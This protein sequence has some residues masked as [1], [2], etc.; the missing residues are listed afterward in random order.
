[1]TLVLTEAEIDGLLK[2][3]NVRLKES[4][5]ID[6]ERASREIQQL[7]DEELHE[8]LLWVYQIR[9]SHHVV[10]FRGKRV[11]L[12]KLSREELAFFHREVQRHELTASHSEG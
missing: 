5:D 1:M 9:Y 10:T 7:S 3:A 4:R 2:E 6:G 8:R 12:G 11:R